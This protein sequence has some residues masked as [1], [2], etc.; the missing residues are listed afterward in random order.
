MNGRRGVR[1][2]VTLNKT[3]HDGRHPPPGDTGTHPPPFVGHA[4]K[5]S[6][7]TPL[8]AW[9]RRLLMA[10]ADRQNTGPSSRRRPA[11]LATPGHPSGSE[12]R[13]SSDL[14]TPL[15]FEY[16]GRAARNDVRSVVRARARDRPPRQWC[17]RR[18][19]R[20]EPPLHSNRRRRGWSARLCAYPE[21]DGFDTAPFGDLLLLTQIT[22]LCFDS[23]IFFN[24]IIF[25]EL[26]EFFD[27]LVHLYFH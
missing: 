4:P 24:L 11:T 3:E 9:S 26:I 25:V 23:I 2:K 8:P 14:H 15:P 19:G 22:N 21:L 5:R 10:T 27:Y 16:S 18:P 12:P 1:K 20:P 7:R 13:S 17:S 6:S